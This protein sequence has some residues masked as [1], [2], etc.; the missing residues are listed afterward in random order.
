VLN[1]TA[2]W[3]KVTRKHN[4]RVLGTRSLTIKRQHGIVREEEIKIF[5]GLTLHPFHRRIS[6]SPSPDEAEEEAH[7]EKR[8]HLIVPLY[9]YSGNLSFLFLL[10]LFFLFTMTLSVAIIGSGVRLERYVDVLDP[11]VSPGRHSTMGVD[12]LEY[13]P[14]PLAVLKMAGEAI[15]DEQRFDCLRS[16]GREGRSGM[17]L[18]SWERGY[19]GECT[20]RPMLGLPCPGHPSNQA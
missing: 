4:G 12:R 1:T 5:Q 10:F 20:V 2:S 3:E 16:A 6:I 8:L 7:Q 13:I 9:A 14:S 11:R 17:C 18:L 15:R 19:T